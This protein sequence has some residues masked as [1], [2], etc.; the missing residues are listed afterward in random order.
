LWGSPASPTTQKPQAPYHDEARSSGVVP[1]RV[2][3]LN[4][5]CALM[6]PLQGASFLSTPLQGGI[7]KPPALRV[8]GDLSTSRI[9]LIG[10]RGLMKRVAQGAHPATLSLAC[11]RYAQTQSNP[12]T[13]GVSL[14]QCPDADAANCVTAT[15]SLPWYSPGLHTRHRHRHPGRIRLVHGAHAYGRT[16]ST[17]N[18]PKCCTHPYT[19]VYRERWWL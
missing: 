5:E 10:F 3:S 8:V 2:P 12:G 4:E 19:P 6:H 14:G 11:G 16:P 15:K 9:A 13:A 17:A 7:L 18:A 1:R